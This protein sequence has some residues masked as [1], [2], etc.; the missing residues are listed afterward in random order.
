MALD[1]NI[2]EMLNAMERSQIPSM[3][4]M[5]PPQARE[6][7]KRMF[8]GMEITQV[9]VFAFED[10][11]IP[12]PAGIIQIRIY[13]PEGEGPHPVL[14]FFHGGGF[15]LGDLDTYD[16]ACRRLCTRS[17]HAVVS[18]NYRLAPEHKFPAA[19]EDCMAA[20]RW[21][22]ESAASINGDPERICVAGDSAGGNLA[23]V[24]AQR[25]RDGALDDDP[26]LAGQVLFYPVTYQVGPDTASRKE[27]AEGY[28]L[29]R[30]DMAWFGGHYFESVEAARSPEA[31]PANADSL[32]G[33][34]PA[35]VVTAGYD[36]LR[37]EGEDYAR[38]LEEAGV[39]TTLTSYED[40]IHGFLNFYGVT[41]RSD[42]VVNEASEWLK[43]IAS[44]EG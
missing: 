20:T 21:V 35:L 25:A 31:S 18:V 3:N 30:E 36:P 28:F 37:D 42:E 12:G 13:T 24:V 32:A 43:R 22:A 17:G 39:P 9:P 40:M 34:P 5:Q 16:P 38:A 1:P 23:A 27:N 7:L 19:V 33:L 26:A 41:E 11:E 44:V 8:L 10:R 4:Q 14:V 6:M 15:V 2:Q 29:T